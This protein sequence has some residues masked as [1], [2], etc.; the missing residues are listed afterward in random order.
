MLVKNRQRKRRRMRRRQREMKICQYLVSNQFY[1][2]R[3]W[4]KLWDPFASLHR[5]DTKRFQYVNHRFVCKYW[6]KIIQIGTWIV[7]AFCQ[8]RQSLKMRRLNDFNLWFRV[9]C[10]S[11]VPRRYGKLHCN[12][13]TYLQIVIIIIR[14]SQ[15]VFKLHTQCNVVPHVYIKCFTTLHFMTW[16]NAM[17]CEWMIPQQIDNYTC[18]CNTCHK[19][20]R[21]G[22]IVERWKRMRRGCIA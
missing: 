9:L 8:Q 11:S 19:N 17:L 18:I 6:N 5:T 7:W 13:C 1:N 16:M 10:L 22:A 3:L 20:H 14:S 15:K 12:A 4:R 2:F 21:Q